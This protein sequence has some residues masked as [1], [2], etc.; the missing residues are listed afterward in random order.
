MMDHDIEMLRWW[1]TRASDT[2]AANDSAQ[3]NIA[4]QSLLDAIHGRTFEL[5]AHPIHRDIAARLDESST[6]LYDEGRKA[7]ALRASHA[8]EELVPGIV[9]AE[10]KAHLAGR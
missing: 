4:V 9:S 7:I 3:C 6:Y 10:H 1:V 2:D 5:Q 8:A